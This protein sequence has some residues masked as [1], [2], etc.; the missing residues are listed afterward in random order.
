MGSLKKLLSVALS[1]A[2]LA[3]GT[4][5]AFAAEYD[6]DE[7]DEDVHHIHS[8][9]GKTVE[10]ERH[11]SSLPE[12]R[13]SHDNKTPVMGSSDN[14]TRKSLFKKAYKVRVQWDVVPGAV[15]Y[16]LAL[17][18]GK[19][20]IPNN[21][22][23]RYREIYTNGTE[24]D[25]SGFGEEKADFYWKVRP[26]D[27][28]RNGIEGYSTPA[29]ITIGVPD[30][31]AP[32][33][34]TEYEKMQLSSLYPVYSWI[35]YLNARS[36]EIKV[37]S[38]DLTGSAKCIRTLY[39]TSMDKYDDAG[40]TSPG[41]YFWRVRALNGYGK[42]ISSWSRKA[43]FRVTRP[44]NVAALGDSITHGG[45]AVSVPPGYRL[46]DWESYCDIPVKN[47]GFSGNTVA[48]MNERFSRDVLPFAPRILVIMGGVNDYRNG[49]DAWTIIN[50]LESLR[51]KCRANGIIPVFL[52][53]TPLNPDLIAKCGFINMPPSDWGTQ[54]QI[55]NQW[56]MSQKYCIDITSALADYRGWME[57]A[58]TTD[59]LH[60]DFIGKKYIGERVA[61][62]LHANFAEI[63]Q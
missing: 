46:Y 5:T 24:I 42:P 61:S 30:A 34:T 38:E 12:R 63:V 48:D 40:Y 27:F 53:V 20:N 57:N 54:L 59:G 41:A 56:V 28:D 47:L 58:I 52:T 4:A 7:E 18:R 49:T 11:G 33:P 43:Y 62:Y 51:S 21:I 25:L 1:I 44:V 16:E 23:T 32:E 22:I 13:V 19:E 3:V 50:G 14:D 36:Y 35:P 6:G 26:M 37:Y 10:I 45:G 55:V 60:P 29:P 8:E 2:I 31:D 15:S 39:S 9:S 17:M